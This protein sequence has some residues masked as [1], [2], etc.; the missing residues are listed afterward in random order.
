M[1]AVLGLCSAAQMACCCTGTAVSLCCNACPSC[2]NSTSSRLMYAI[3]LLFGAIL[4]AIALAPGLQDT[5]RKVPFCANSTSTASL[6]IPSAYSSIDCSSAVGYL[7]V[8]RICFALVCFFLLMAVMMVGVRS[9]QDPRA[10]IQ[11]GFWGMKFLIVIGITIGAF[12]IPEGNFG[13]TWMWIGLIGGLAFILVQLVLIVD[14]AHTWAESW[15]SNYEENESRGWYCA[16]LSAT[17][18]QYILAITGIVMLYIYYTVSNDCALNKFFIS[19]NLIFCVIVSVVSVL[20]AVQERLP[21]SGLLQNRVCNPGFLG[22][23]GEHS[24]KVTFDKTS[25]IGLIIWM[26]CVLYSSLRSASQVA[27]VANP[28]PEKQATLTEDD[29]KPATAGDADGKVWDNEE[30]GVAYS[31]TLFHVVF[32]T[33]TLYVMM[34]LTNWYQP[35]STLE[36]MNANAASMWVKI[37]S[38]W[39]CLALYAWSLVA[40]IVLSDRDFGV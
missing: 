11:N 14:F 4:G 29:S 37:I 35:N 16:L 28:D 33:A 32:A 38:S 22:I 15:V 20:P 3:M 36:T 10:P 13:Y 18:L 34:T 30:S 1:G 8:Y 39:L 9:S 23:V 5:L 26:F 31:W 7:A 2:K 40:P 27:R 21:K 19:I 25:I 17:G 12:F 24:N 6:V